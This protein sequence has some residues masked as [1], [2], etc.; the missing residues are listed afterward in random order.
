[1]TSPPSSPELPP[2]HSLV[3]RAL[4]LHVIR[5]R[6]DEIAL[7]DAAGS[8][9]YAHL[10][11]DSASIAGAL[12][13]LGVAEA[14]V[15]AV[16]LPPGRHRVISVLAC[17]RLGAEVGESQTLRLA[18]DPI[19]LQTP[20]TEVPWDVLLRAGRTDPVGAPDADP[21]GY[22]DRF[23]AAHETI[24]APLLAGDAVVDGPR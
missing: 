1:M 24:F 23:G 9:T 18:G 5:G 15:V 6:A 20:D 10:L 17:A 22:A 21:E 4:D 12:L 13:Q 8:M 7:T 16:D 11:H 14:T 2:E 3:F 19:V